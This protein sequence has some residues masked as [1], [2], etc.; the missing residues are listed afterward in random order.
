[1]ARSASVPGPTANTA[2]LVRTA[3]DGEKALETVAYL[4][5]YV[6]WPGNRGFDAGIDHVASRIESAGFVAEETAAAGAR[7]TYRIEAYPMTQP[8]WEPMAAAVTI[9]GQDTPV[10]EFTS[11]RNMLAVGS[12]STPEGGITAELIDVGSG[13]PAELDAAEIQGRIV[14]AEGE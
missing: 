10:L 3:Y 2:D 12:F 1:M 13:T 11:N 4:D 7:L 6:R 14:L 8:A 5:Q 9:T